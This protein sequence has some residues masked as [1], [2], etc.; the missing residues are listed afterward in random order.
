MSTAFFPART[1]RTFSKEQ[2]QRHVA[3]GYAGRHLV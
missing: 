3:L 1:D 2:I